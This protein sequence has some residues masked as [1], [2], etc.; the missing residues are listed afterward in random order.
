MRSV[1]LRAICLQ[2]LQLCW[3]AGVGETCRN[4]TYLMLSS[5]Y[6]TA[7]R[8]C[9]CANA[10][11]WGESCIWCKPVS[12]T[13]V[14]MCGPCGSGLGVGGATGNHSIGLIGFPVT[15]SLCIGEWVQR[16]HCNA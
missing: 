9:V 13:L 12:A 4:N 15:S 6:R 11:L 1:A 2:L 5:R 14:G 10:L 7:W 8:K 3:A 16:N